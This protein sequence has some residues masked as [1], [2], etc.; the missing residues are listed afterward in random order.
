MLN[1]LSK[2]FGGIW[3][4]VAAAGGIALAVLTALGMAKRSG[5]KQEQ[6]AETERSLKESREANAIDDKVHSM[7]DSQLDEELRK[8]RK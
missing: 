7:S 4:Y 6:A 8:A 1:L 2:F 3:G 5:V